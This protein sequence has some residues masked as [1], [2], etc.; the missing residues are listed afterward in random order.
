MQEMGSNPLFAFRRWV[1]SQQ[2]NLTPFGPA[3]PG[4]FYGCWI[5]NEIVGPWKETRR[6]NG[7]SRQR[8]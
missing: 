6:Q 5:T 3:Q 1:F 4:Y 8:L 7:G 2:L